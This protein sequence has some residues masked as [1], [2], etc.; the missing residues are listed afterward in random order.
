[1]LCLHSSIFVAQASLGRD[2]AATQIIA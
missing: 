1:V 2:S